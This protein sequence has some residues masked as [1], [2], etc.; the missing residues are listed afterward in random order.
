M[1]TFIIKYW[2]LIIWS[3]VAI[4]VLTIMGYFIVVKI[5]N[6]IAGEDVAEDLY[7]PQIENVI[8]SDAIKFKLTEKFFRSSKY[9]YIKYYNELALREVH[10]YNDYIC[11]VT[12]KNQYDFK[13]Y[14]IGEVYP[15]KKGEEIYGYWTNDIFQVLGIV[16]KIE[17]EETCAV[18]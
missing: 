3:I 1:I 8:F 15:C 17:E 12:T 10:M 13:T 16:N 4:I 9:I 11:T 6:K 5:I 2:Q 7:E 14:L 18:D